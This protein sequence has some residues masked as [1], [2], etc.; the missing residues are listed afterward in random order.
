MRNI[1]CTFLF[2][3]MKKTFLVLAAIAFGSV[4]YSQDIVVESALTE[5]KSGNLD[6]AKIDIDRA[7]AYPGTKEKPKAL[8]SK[9]RIYMAIQMQKLPKYIDSHPYREAAYALMKLAEV[10]PDYEKADVDVNLFNCAIMFNND[11]VTAFNKKNKAEG[12]ECMLNVV[13][14]HDLNGGKRYE[15]YPD[16]KFP[17]KKLDTIA[18]NALSSAAITYFEDSNYST[19]IPLFEQIVANP[20]TRTPMNFNLLI[21]S[22]SYSK[23]NHE[24]EIFATIDAARKAYPNDKNLRN[25]EMYFYF[26]AGKQEE[27]IKKLEDAVTTEPDNAELNFNLAVLYLNMLNSKENAAKINHTEVAAK[28]E[29]AFTKAVAKAPDSPAYNYN[30]GVLYY[31]QG[32]VLNEQMNALA[33]KINEKGAKNAKTEQTQ[34]DGL[35]KSRDDFFAKATTYFEKAYSLLD[36]RSS[37]LNKEDKVTYSNC[38]TALKDAYTILGKDDKYKEMKAKL[39]AFEQQ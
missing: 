30:F 8:Y 35:K 32:R 11:G 39:D 9:S 2:S 34:Y 6:Q 3:I 18:A 36:P 1:T 16:D 4:A 10:K 14:I 17:K 31:D 20:I 5:L 23:G 28:A 25:N 19:A 33:D 13:K 7:I 37:S 21:E 26:K 27:L 38:L 15:K 24:K 29:A 22:Y 12:V